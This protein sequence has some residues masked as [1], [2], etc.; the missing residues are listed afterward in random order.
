MAELN[1]KVLKWAVGRSGLA[2]DQVLRAF[3][4]FPEWVAGTR[5]PTVRQ[6]QNF[7][8]RMHV[9]V[10][11]LFGAEFPDYALQIAD[12]RTVD[13]EKAKEPSAALF[14]TID[15]MLSRQDWMRDYFLSEGH[16]PIDFVGSFKNMSLT[17]E[18]IEK[19]VAA[20]H[21]ALGLEEGWAASCRNMA[22]A[23]K[24]LK[25]A[26]EHLGISVVINGVVNDNTHRT[27]D[28]AE[29][30]GFV[31][32][33]S[34]APLIFINGR[35]NKSAQIF[36]LVHELCHLAFSQTG[37][38][39]APEDEVS[40][41]EMERFCNEVAADFLVPD[42]LLAEKLDG[43]KSKKFEA[44]KSIAHDCKI[45]FVVAARKAK[46]RGYISEDEFFAMWRRY[47][48]EIPAE[49]RSGK[50]GNYYLNKQYE[51]GSVFSEAVLTAVNNNYLSYRDAYDLTGM[52]APNFKKYFEAVV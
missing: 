42:A 15:T 19:L 25:D 1:P 47:Q 14:D 37:V 26:I 5:V 39:N 3:P 11:E 32:S 48:R 21:E 45:N 41:K 46:D 8:E 12:F 16:D 31:L 20:M 9:S 43:A 50:G 51:L 10:S 24:Q 40:D 29:F 7:A 2:D 18:T 52:T 17:S 38:S 49:A 34:V 23:L 44:I 30:R 36:T 33:D 13:D 4:K 22:D 27:L 6:L 35:D 28:V